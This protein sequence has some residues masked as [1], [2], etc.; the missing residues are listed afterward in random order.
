MFIELMFCAVLDMSLPEFQPQEDLSGNYIIGSYDVSENE[1]IV[2]DISSSDFLPIESENAGQFG[3]LSADGLRALMLE[4]TRSTQLVDKYVF[5]QTFN[6]HRVH[7]NNDGY[8]EIQVHSSSKLNYIK[9]DS[10]ITYTITAFDSP[11]YSFTSLSGSHI[12]L[13]ELSSNVITPSSNIYVTGGNGSIYATYQVE[14][15]VSDGDVDLSLLEGL[16]ESIND[17]IQSFKDDIM[18]VIRAIL[19]IA[20]V[21]FLYPVTMACINY[22]KGDKNNV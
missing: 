17:N 16:V 12:P 14:E 7:E 1:F 10:D 18:I 19:F 20:L 22:L 6:G 4:S 11:L 9:L 3:G 2:E 21:T 13:T 15:T 8:F 5:S